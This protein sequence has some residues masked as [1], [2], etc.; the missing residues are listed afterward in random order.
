MSSQANGPA[1]EA[2]AQ[3]SAGSQTR[4]VD[5]V[6]DVEALAARLREA[7]SLPELLAVSFEA[8]EA[9]RVFARRSEDTVPWLFAAFMMAADAA[10]D[11][12]EAITTAPSLS[13]A[14]SG[15]LPAGPPAA[16]AE[17]KTITDAIA[18]LGG[19]L[20]ERLTDAVNRAHIPGDRAACEE[21]A[22]AGR[23]IHRLMARDDDDRRI[24]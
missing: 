19:L 22:Q 13:P 14:P 10:V 1:A 2:L 16:D 4:K 17:I 11:G 15:T 21:A 6:Q 7:C 9:I 12:R 3:Q 5:G 20:D 24:R 23:R 18:A 8:F